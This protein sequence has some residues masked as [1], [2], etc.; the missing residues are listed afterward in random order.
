MV[1]HCKQFYCV[2]DN[3]DLNEETLDGKGT[4]HCTYIT[5]VQQALEGM[6]TNTTPSY[7]YAEPL[8]P[9]CSNDKQ[10]RS[11]IVEPEALPNLIVPI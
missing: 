7:I 5:I 8:P 1:N 4:M 9:T 2:A 3:N 11:I 6:Q 10:K